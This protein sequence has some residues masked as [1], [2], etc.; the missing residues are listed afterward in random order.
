MA[1]EQDFERDF[2][3][4]SAAPA[5]VSTNKSGE[6]K[7]NKSLPFAFAGPLLLCFLHLIIDPARHMIRSVVCLCLVVCI[8]RKE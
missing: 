1:P 6:Y 8:G 2:F 7:H 4:I 3:H 5:P